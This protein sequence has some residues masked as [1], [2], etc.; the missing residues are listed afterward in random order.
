M[1]AFCYNNITSFE[2][3]PLEVF[4][5]KQ[6][7]DHYIAIMNSRFHRKSFCQRKCHE[8]LVEQLIELKDHKK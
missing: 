5:E 4:V 3:E 1:I 6:I 2:L 8:F 7:N